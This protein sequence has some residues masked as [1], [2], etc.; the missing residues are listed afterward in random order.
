MG[1]GGRPLGQKVSLGW[2][3]A[4]RSPVAQKG[5]GVPSVWRNVGTPAGLIGLEMSF[6]PKEDTREESGRSVE[7]FLEQTPLCLET[8]FYK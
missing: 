8:R 6:F 3:L 5:S 7:T 2:R 4:H 1:E